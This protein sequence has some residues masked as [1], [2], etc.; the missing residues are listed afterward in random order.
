MRSVVFFKKRRVERGRFPPRGPAGWG[1][2]SFER[3]I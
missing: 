2:I 1:G 3:I